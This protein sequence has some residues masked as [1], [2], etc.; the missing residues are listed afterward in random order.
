[1]NF[2]FK[3]L[4]FAFESANIYYFI[5]KTVSSIGKKKSERLKKLLENNTACL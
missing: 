3:F 4:N 1:M 2:F 5:K